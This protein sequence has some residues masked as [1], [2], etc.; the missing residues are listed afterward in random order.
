M[1]KL[2]FSLCCVKLS[3]LLCT[4]QTRALQRRQAVPGSGF[5]FMSAEELLALSLQVLPMWCYTAIVTADSASGYSENSGSVLTSGR[6]KT[7][8]A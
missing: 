4:V 6:V 1:A 2:T 5:F 7:S 8:V 3:G